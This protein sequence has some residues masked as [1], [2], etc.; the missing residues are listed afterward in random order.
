MPRSYILSTTEGLYC[1]LI[2]LC[3]TIKVITFSPL[4]GYLFDTRTVTLTKNKS[5]IDPAKQ[6]YRKIMKTVT[7]HLKQIII[8]L[9]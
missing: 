5:V 3:M 6:K 7:S 1:C 4:I 2:T 9:M 8:W